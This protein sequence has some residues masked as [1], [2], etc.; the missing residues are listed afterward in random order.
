MKELSKTD[1]IKIIESA[2]KK[3]G[4]YAELLCNGW[5]YEKNI[6]SNDFDVKDEAKWTANVEGRYAYWVAYAEK[7]ADYTDLELEIQGD[8]RGEIITIK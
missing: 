6:T 2:S 4:K 3:A 5:Q 8:P 1:A 7:I